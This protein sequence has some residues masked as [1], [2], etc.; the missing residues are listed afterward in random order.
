M[1]PTVA[2]AAT[3]PRP[4][5]VIADTNG[6]DAP[7]DDDATL[8]DVQRW[9]RRVRHAC[10][11]LRIVHAY[12]DSVSKFRLWILLL[13]IATPIPKFT[14]LCNE[15]GCV[16]HDL[17]LFV[18]HDGCI[19][20]TLS[21]DAIVV[22]VAAPR[23][24]GQV[25]A[26]MRKF[27][28]MHACGDRVIDYRIINRDG[29]VCIAPEVYPPRFVWE[30]KDIRRIVR[31]EADPSMLRLD[32]RRTR[33][34]KHLSREEV[35]HYRPL[36]RSC[37]PTTD[38]DDA[39]S[40]ETFW[41][42]LDDGGIVALRNAPPRLTPSLPWSPPHRLDPLLLADPVQ[43]DVVTL[44][45]QVDTSVECGLRALTCDALPL[46]LKRYIV[47]F[48]S[49][50]YGITDTLIGVV[51]T[52][53]ASLA[54]YDRFVQVMCRVYHF[55]NT[56]RVHMTD[57]VRFLRQ[58]EKRAATHHEWDVWLESSAFVAE[59]LLVCPDRIASVC[60]SLK[61]VRARCLAI[62]HLTPLWDVN[63]TAL[64]RELVSRNLAHG[65]VRD[66]YVALVREHTRVT[67]ETLWK[68]D[69]VRND[70]VDKSKAL[71]AP[72]PTRTARMTVFHEKDDATVASEE[73][74]E[75]EDD[76]PLMGGATLDDDGTRSTPLA[77][78]QS[79]EI[80]PGGG[81]ARPRGD[82]DAHRDD[83]AHGHCARAARMAAHF[84]MEVSLIGSGVFFVAHDMDVVVSPRACDGAAP[85]AT[86]QAAVEW[87]CK[88][89][90]WSV[91]HGDHTIDGDRSTAVLL[92][93]TFEG[94]RV[95]AQV[96]R[97]G[98]SAPWT[99]AERRAHR[100]V[101]HTK[102]L[103]TRSD[104]RVR[105]SIR[106]LHAWSE[107]AGVKGHVWCRMPGIAVTVVAIAVA[108]ECDAVIEAHHDV[109][110]PASSR[111]LLRRVLRA[112]CERLM[113]RGTPTI[114]HDE[115]DGA[116]PPPS[117]P[118]SQAGE[119]P[120]EAL[121]VTTSTHEADGRLN[122]RMTGATTRW[123]HMAIK[124]G[125]AATDEELLC[126]AHYRPQ[127]V[128]DRAVPAALVLPRDGMASVVATL[129][130]VL[131][132]LEHHPL[133]DAIHVEE[134]DD[135]LCCVHVCP[136][137][138]VSARYGWAPGE[139]TVHRLPWPTSPA[140]PKRPAGIARVRVHPTT[141]AAH[142]TTA[143]RGGGRRTWTTL[144]FWQGAD[145][146]RRPPDDDFP[147]QCVLCVGTEAFPGSVLR[148]TGEPW[149][150]ANAPFLACDVANRFT[151]TGAWTDAIA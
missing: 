128:C 109:D 63:E 72:L 141:A 79:S 32:H 145:D 18:T 1:P 69:D 142:S 67:T 44:F 61:R 20:Y 46:H 56:E 110:D 19:V 42:R 113:R 100:A 40:D 83:V 122:S 95:D 124:R 91:D 125:L 38:T 140:A 53:L 12:D 111:A 92:R 3:L 121:S 99:F 148:M 120:D 71:H 21:T 84:G 41:V 77:Q 81:A 27:D 133:V 5:C 80:A 25:E 93:G 74:E 62:L 127:L 132:V 151:A 98:G 51:G 59:C 7:L 15:L 68:T 39:T 137:A 90:G 28:A 76:D 22:N 29:E 130:S 105:G 136:R 14:E 134:L 54:V 6:K 65:D 126:A 96:C 117:A 87:I 34:V 35:C 143:S 16:S 149:C 88:R 106:V 49:H 108:S 147:E 45:W 114:H 112:V 31:D 23:T 43:C 119:T 50:T 102:M 4:L 139:Y 33:I 24:M 70:A 48:L 26:L 101:M 135:A 116:P 11:I 9:E 138:H 66:R 94:V 13:G 58:L 47:L 73:E 52:H 10:K 55:M 115:V 86:L 150:V 60:G 107:A 144:A 146:G 82:A 8:S 97:R 131:A 2:E 64:A 118:A 17:L 57:L 85:V 78:L 104:R 129:Y 123:L 89:T 103:E 37:I 30:R 75:H 36:A